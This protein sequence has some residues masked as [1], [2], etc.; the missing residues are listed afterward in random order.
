MASLPDYMSVGDSALTAANDAP[1][2]SQTGLDQPQPNGQ[3]VCR[4]PAAPIDSRNTPHV[5]RPTCYNF[6]RLSVCLMDR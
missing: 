4:N 2:I 3:S 6:P 5:L 1:D